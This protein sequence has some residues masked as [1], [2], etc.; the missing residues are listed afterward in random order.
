[1]IFRDGIG[2]VRCIFVSRRIIFSKGWRQD[3]INLLVNGRDFP[4]LIKWILGIYFCSNRLNGQR[5][6]I[7]LSYSLSYHLPNRA[8]TTAKK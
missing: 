7:C 3:L 8:I 4:F 5:K 6:K 2:R 1:M